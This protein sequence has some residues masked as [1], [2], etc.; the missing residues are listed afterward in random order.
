[1]CRGFFT[2]AV[3]TIKGIQCENSV[4]G[5]E[6]PDERFELSDFIFILAGDDN[7][8]RGEESMKLCVLI[9]SLL[10]IFEVAPSPGADASICN[11]G[12]NV[13][14]YP[15]GQLKS[16]PLR[17]IF[18]LS[19]VTCNVLAVAEFYELGML[20]SC[21]TRDFFLYEGIVCSEYGKV[22]FYESGKLESCILSRRAEGDGKIC[23]ELEP[24]YLFENGKLKSCGTPR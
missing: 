4:K 16:C 11:P 6:A 22:S 12:T 10:L 8:A 21:V 20:K 1:M 13:I 24:I 19:G 18:L 5:R 9:L 2:G 3:K 7:S 14:Y 15:N 23:V 17:D